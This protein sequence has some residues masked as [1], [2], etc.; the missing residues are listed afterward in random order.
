MYLSIQD[1][2]RHL[3]IDHSDD[4]KYIADLITVAEDAVR[5]DLNLYSLKEIE[6]CSGML[7]A[8]VTQAML[9]LIGTLFANRESVTYGAPHSVPHSYEYLLDLCRNYIN[10]A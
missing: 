8:C 9:L 5:R 10:K 7:P 6:D 4:D 1:V 3:Y 2:K